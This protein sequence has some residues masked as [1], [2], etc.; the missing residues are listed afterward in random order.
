MKPVVR[1]DDL[2]YPELSYKLVGYAFEVFNELGPG[3]SEKTYQN[4]YA[5]ILRKNNH[6][7]VEQAYYP[8][9]FKGQVVSKGFLDFKVEEKVIIELKKNGR[10][11]KTH[12]DQVLDYLKRSGL[13]LALLIQFSY[14]GVLFKRIVNVNI[15]DETNSPKKL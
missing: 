3:H 8:V 10:Y 14:D 4:A 7:F 1:R 6:N 5:L 2:L 11:S 15:Y 12:M 13:K 9:R